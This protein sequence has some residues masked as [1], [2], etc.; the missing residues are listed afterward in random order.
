MSYFSQLEQVQEILARG[1]EGKQ[2]K[3]DC[4]KQALAL[5]NEASLRLAQALRRAK[6]NAEKLEVYFNY[7]VP[8]NDW[9]KSVDAQFCK[10]KDR[11][12]GWWD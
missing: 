8:S 3:S 6:T 2:K 7:A 1:V 10:K 5:R 4:V 11:K 12:A 9:T